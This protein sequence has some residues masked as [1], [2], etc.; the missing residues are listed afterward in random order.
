MRGGLEGSGKKEG[1]FVWEELFNVAED[2]FMG[3]GCRGS[4]SF[5][6]LYIMHDVRHAFLELNRIRTYNELL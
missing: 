3:G 6:M 2:R 1:T 5:F 4:R